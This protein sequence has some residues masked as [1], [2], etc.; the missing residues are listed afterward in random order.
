MHSRGLTV[1][2]A[3]PSRCI[4]APLAQLRTAT[5]R[6][7]NRLSSATLALYS[8]LLR[9][10]LF[11]QKRQERF[12]TFIFHSFGWN[13]M[14]GG[15][16]NGVNLSGGRFRVGKEIA[17]VGI[18]SFGAHLGALHIVRSVQLLDEEIFR[19]RFA[20]CGYADLTV[21]FVERSKEWFAGNDIDVDAGT[22]VIPEFVLKRRL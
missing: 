19:D 5:L 10:L 3:L 1:Y 15:R 20:K 22:L 16:V 6:R 8:D 18:A 14:E 12:V 2:P 21:E 9:T 7:L 17:K 13:E 4:D 11:L